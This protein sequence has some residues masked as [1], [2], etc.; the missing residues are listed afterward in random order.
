M[1]SIAKPLFRTAPIGLVV[2]AA[3]FAIRFAATTVRGQPATDDQPV[4]N[5]PTTGENATE[6]LGQVLHSGRLPPITPIPAPANPDAVLLYP[7]AMIEAPD[8][9]W[10][11]YVGGPICRNVVRP[12]ITP[13][14]PDP[15]KATGAAVIV[16]SG[17]GF[18]YLGMDDA[19]IVQQLADRGIA[20]FL[21][22]Y[23]LLPT[24][25]NPQEFLSKMF[26]DLAEIAAKRD[27]RSPASA[28]KVPEFALADARAAVRLVRSR[29][30]GWHVDPQRVGFIGGS[31]GAVL[32]VQVGLSP[33][34]ADRPDF[35]GCTS[36]FVPVTEVPSYAPPLFLAVTLDDPLFSADTGALMPLWRKA[37]RPVEAHFYEI[38]GH[39]LPSTP[40]TSTSMWFDSFCAWMNTRGLMAV[41]D[42]APLTGNWIIEYDIGG[43]AK[44]MPASLKQ[45]RGKV[46]GTIKGPEGKDLPIAGKEEDAKVTLQ[47]EYEYEGNSL[48]MVYIGTL[49]AAG[50]S[51]SGYCEVRPM[52]VEGTFT[53]RKK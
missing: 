16:A 14:L 24:S 22:K 5:Q 26:Q 29:A 49:N 27:S 18:W 36:G 15:A 38:G 41:S 21:L 51:I 42:A 28:I 46:A 31:A 6:Q 34:A 13:F 43:N 47:F 1:Y 2:L 45:E 11:N 44:A 53:A 25:R 39:G 35:L 12:T 50:T 7:D 32:T 23:R 4:I 20:A 19:K 30:T 52:G 3:A 9:Q 40:G 8:E 37:G 10:E 33:E 48:T 17:G